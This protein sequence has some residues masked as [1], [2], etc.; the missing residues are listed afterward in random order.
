VQHHLLI[1]TR[2][3]LVLRGGEGEIVTRFLRAGCLRLDPPGIEVEI[4]AL[5]AGTDVA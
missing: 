1:D 5:Y 3:R 4:A 2:R